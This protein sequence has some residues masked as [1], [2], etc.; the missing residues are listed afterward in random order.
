MFWDKFESNAYFHVINTGLTECLRLNSHLLL[1]RPLSNNGIPTYLPKFMFYH[2]MCTKF[3]DYV[4]ING[5]GATFLG[6]S[7]ESIG[8]Y[9]ICLPSIKEQKMIVEFLD[10][11]LVK[12][13]QSIDMQ[14]QQIEKL[15][16]YKATLINSAVTG[17]IKVV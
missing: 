3:Q 10:K 7:Q 4:K 11:Q 5:T 6:I 17:K 14:E 9:P 13:E 1:F 16:E 15:K 12:F 8:N 2:M